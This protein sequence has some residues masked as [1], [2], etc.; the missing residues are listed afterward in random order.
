MRVGKPGALEDRAGR[1]DSAAS[2]ELVGPQE[3]GMACEKPARRRG[4]EMG[5]QTEAEDRCSFL[6][7]ALGYVQMWAFLFFLSS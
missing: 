6:Q 4:R 7:G 1:Q 5:R 3:Q 2:R